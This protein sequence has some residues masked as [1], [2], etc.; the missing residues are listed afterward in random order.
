MDE[1]DLYGFTAL[2]LA[3]SHGHVETVRVLLECGAN[4]NIINCDGHTPLEYCC[5]SRRFIDNERIRRQDDIGRALLAHNGSPFIASTCD[6]DVCGILSEI[7]PKE[8]RL[9]WM[10]KIAN[11]AV[12]LC[13]YSAFTLLDVETMMLVLAFL[14]P[15]NKL[16]RRDVTEVLTVIR[17][18]PSPDTWKNYQQK[19]LYV[20]HYEDR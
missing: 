8:M 7:F 5:G 19:K 14:Y 1:Q 9:A 18:L 13:R 10:R 4:S 20:H 15:D 11:R 3:S 2:H 12:Q 17:E 6:R 16:S